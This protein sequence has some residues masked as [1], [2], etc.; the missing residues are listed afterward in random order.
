MHFNPSCTLHIRDIVAKAINKLLAHNGIQ[1]DKFPP[2][3]LSIDTHELIVEN[4]ET[5]IRDE[6]YQYNVQ[7]T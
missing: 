4:A 7:A 3:L 5:E 6:M 1:I 2:L